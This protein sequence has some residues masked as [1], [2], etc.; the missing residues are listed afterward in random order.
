MSK[1]VYK[2]KRSVFQVYVK[3]VFADY[4]TW[5]IIAATIGTLVGT[6]TAFIKKMIL[7]HLRL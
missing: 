3:S 5:T 1:K 6:I 4:S 2:R 7:L